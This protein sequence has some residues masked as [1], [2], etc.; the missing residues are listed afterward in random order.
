MAAPLVVKTE[1]DHPVDNCIFNGLRWLFYGQAPTPSPERRDSLTRSGTVLA[2]SESPRRRGHR[3]SKELKEEFPA[4]AFPGAAPKVQMQAIS[5]ENL[6]EVATQAVSPQ[7][8]P[9]DAP[10]LY[11]RPPASAE[12]VL[13]LDPGSGESCS[14]LQSCMNVHLAIGPAYDEQVK[15]YPP[16]WKSMVGVRLTEAEAAADAARPVPKSSWPG[17]HDLRG[18]AF[19]RNLATWASALYDAPS[20]TMHAVD[21]ASSGADR[22]AARQLEPRPVSMGKLSCLVCG[23]RG[24]QVTLPALWR[25]GCRLPSVV[26]N[27]GCA[28]ERAAWVWPAGVH[29]VLLTGG[30]D[31]ICNEFAAWGEER[32]DAAQAAYLEQ[33]WHAVP[34]A[35]QRTTAILHVAEMGHRPEAA[36]LRCVLPALVRYVA[37]GLDPSAKPTAEALRGCALTCTLATADCPEGERLVDDAT[38]GAPAL[39]EPWLAEEAGQVT[40]EVRDAS[41]EVLR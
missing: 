13:L 21:L 12:R 6:K 41:P 25:L 16:H 23:S 8:R 10:P 3:F 40:D 29:V 28:R 39:G 37:T 14:A 20:A 26:I 1:D 27:G 32:A 38:A 34:P 30:R 18:P 9:A 5:P 35:N 22:T 36:L 2:L 4:L 31:T 11:P 19:P 24:G 15:R 17:V 7:M 33:L